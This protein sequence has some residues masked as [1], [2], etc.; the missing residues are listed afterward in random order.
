VLQ[1]AG[2]GLHPVIGIKLRKPQELLKLIHHKKDIHLL[3]MVAAAFTHDA[4]WK[5][6]RHFLHV[7][8]GYARVGVWLMHHP[9]L[10]VPDTCLRPLKH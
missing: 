1:T 9:G 10:I 7:V 4:P 5:N 6:E 3:E 8:E 2:F